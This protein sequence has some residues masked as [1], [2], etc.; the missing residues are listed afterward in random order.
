MAKADKLMMLYA[1]L[2]M[3]PVR[4][5]ILSGERKPVFKKGGS[6]CHI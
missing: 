2:E 6:L 3:L 1:A 4:Y 5:L